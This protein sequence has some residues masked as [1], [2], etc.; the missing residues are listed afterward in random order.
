[1]KINPWK[2]ITTYIY[3]KCRT[4][5]HDK[6]IYI[7]QL[8]VKTDFIFSTTTPFEMKN[9]NIFLINFQ[10]NKEIN[11]S[12]INSKHE[13][14]NTDT[15]THT[16]THKTLN[17]LRIDCVI[18]S[19][20]PFNCNENLNFFSLYLQ[21][22]KKQNNNFDLVWNLVA[23]IVT[24][25]YCM[26]FIQ[27]FIIIINFLWAFIKTSSAVRH[28]TTKKK[29]KAEIDKE[30]KFDGSINSRQQSNRAG[31][32]TVA[33]KKPVG[34]SASTESSTSTESSSGSTTARNTGAIFTIDEIKQKYQNPSINVPESSTTPAAT[35]TTTRT[36]PTADTSAVTTTTA[37][38]EKKPFQSRFLAPK[39]EPIPPPTPPAA[40]DETETSSEEE[41][42]SDES[43]EEEDE[44]EEEVKP[45]PKPILKDT[46]SRTTETNRRSSRDDAGVSS[47][48]RT[49]YSSPSYKSSF[50]RDDSPKYGSTTSSS[51]R[52]RPTASS[53]DDDH[54]YGAGS[55]SSG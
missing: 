25:I 55:S 14:L 41:T 45:T 52:S 40:K 32:Q 50:D 12:E 34:R 11:E 29:T 26:Q 35:T 30:D 19:K 47:P 6:V 38:P 5:E 51:V 9:F 17:H 1:M 53:H 44:E 54:R 27:F 3:E 49:G 21:S 33:A 43:D 22:L 8:Y 13:T 10:K 20:S 36:R 16:K 42:S 15:N 28:A 2:E 18:H 4:V 46:S 24:T 23:S 39:S 7:L 48:T 37:P 31:S